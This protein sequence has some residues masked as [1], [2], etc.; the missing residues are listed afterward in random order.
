M[1]SVKSDL[2]SEKYTLA[3]IV[4]F[5]LIIYYPTIFGELCVL[6]DLVIS[7]GYLNADNEGVVYLLNNI[8]FPKDNGLYYRPVVHLTFI[9]DQ[10]MWFF[11]PA[12]AKFENIVIHICNTILV[13][14]ISRRYLYIKQQENA[15]IPLIVSLLF[16]LHPINTE[17]VNWISGR[18]DLLAGLFVFLAFYNILKYKDNDEKKYLFYTFVFTCLG[19]LTK[20]V[21]FGFVAALP[22][23]YYA[24]TKNYSNGV[25]KSDRVI[26]IFI[27]TLVILSLLI[28]LIILLRSI[29]F[30][31]TSEN[32]SNTLNL[33][34]DKPIHVILTGLKGYGFYLKKIF[35]PTPLSFAITDVSRNYVVV[36]LFVVIVVVYGFYVS[37]IESIFFFTGI[38]LIGP[39]LFISLG[40][41]AWTPYAERYVYIASPFI[42]LPFISVIAN[43]QIVKNNFSVYKYAI[44]TIIVLFASITFHRNFIWLDNVSLLGDSVQKNPAYSRLRGEYGISL[45][46]AGMYEE[47]KKQFLI[48][49]RLSNVG[50]SEKYALNYASVLVRQ[51]NMS[52]AE[53]VY[54][55]IFKITNGESSESL[56]QIISFYEILKISA[57]DKEGI[58]I[59]KKIIDYRKLRFEKHHRLDDVFQIGLEYM[60]LQDELNARNYFISYLS[61]NSKEINKAKRAENYLK[62]LGKG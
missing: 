30:F 54:D 55:Q 18:T 41:I 23:L 11:S 13:Y 42:L 52:E 51:N 21:V 29:A 7:S 10:K 20:E 8:F 60:Y 35:I 57:N 62:A 6:D 17:S 5:I 45:S 12:I 58:R 19:L 16:G 3:L 43:S 31:T 1:L 59:I 53:T 2:L 38:S 47:A 49:Q 22:L 44:T 14:K 26:K 9:F 32:I 61:S 39:A 48:A 4:F 36:G 25:S 50:Y 56:D 46:L 28:T 37:N 34:I 27:V 40:K 15:Y 33:F 24:N